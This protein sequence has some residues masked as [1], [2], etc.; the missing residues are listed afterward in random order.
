MSKLAQFYKFINEVFVMEEKPSFLAQFERNLQKDPREE[1]V[2]LLDDAGKIKQKTNYY[3]LQLRAKEIFIF[4]TGNKLETQRVILLFPAGIEFIIAMLSCFYT[5]TIFVPLNVPNTKNFNRLNHVIANCDPKGMLTDVS[6][7]SLL[8]KLADEP[9]VFELENAVTMGALVYIPIKKNNHNK[10]VVK[11]IEDIAFIQYTSGSTFLPKGVIVT[12]SNLNY[13]INYIKSSFQLTSEDVSLTWL[14]NYHDMGLVDGLLLPIYLGCASYIMSPLSFLKNPLIWLKSISDYKV[15]HSGGPNFSYDMCVKRVKKDV[16]MDLNL[17]AW[18]S[19]YN[20][21]E[22]IINETIDNFSECFAA[23]GFNKKSIYPCYGLAE[24]TLMVT[25]CSLIRAPV[26]KRVDSNLLKIGKIKAI[27]NLNNNGQF[28]VSSG[29]ARLDTK[30]LIVEPESKKQLLTN[31]VGEIWVNGPTVAAGYW[32]NEKET[33]NCFNCFTADTK[34]GP[35]LRTGD[36]GFLDENNEL[37]ITG[38]IKDLIIINGENYHP[39]DIEYTAE[40]IIN[41]TRSHISVAFS[42]EDKGANSSKLFLLLQ[43]KN[44]YALNSDMDFLCRKIADQVYDEYRI[45]LN[46][47]L[48]TAQAIPKTTSGKVQRQN[49]KKLYLEGSLQY[50][51]VWENKMTTNKND[52]K[53]K[54][55]TQI[56][57][58]LVFWLANNFNVGFEEIDK[59]A[60]FTTF[61]L[62]SIKIAEMFSSLEKKFIINVPIDLVYSY[63][64]INKLSAYLSDELC[65]LAIVTA[66]TLDL[67]KN[68]DSLKNCFIPDFEIARGT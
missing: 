68:N 19:A 6:T 64:S 42:I 60:D 31:E 20:G 50:F 41:S 29:I 25:G 53:E 59:N 11:N 30:V 27:E 65:D 55:Q 37:F 43:L 22:P 36:L 1:R 3:D 21:A 28:L 38:R 14:P 16:K 13:N 58:H 44:N 54:L 52:E 15:S 7:L 51:Y 46:S 2:F 23:S 63:T 18:K 32:N 34:Q 5:K 47:I 48:L 66:D 12:N 39:Q 24:T 62:D 45:V 4:L 35:F 10:S 8:K 33:S 40:K 17:S 9:H 61:H 26:T 57:N 56:A 49:C 67:P